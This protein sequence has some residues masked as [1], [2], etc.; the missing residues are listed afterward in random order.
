MKTY[1]QLKVGQAFTFEPNGAV[2]IRC[3]GGFRPGRGGPLYDRLADGL[4][5]TNINVYLYR[6]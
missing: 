4:S 6:A 5:M 3:R 1:K 2:F